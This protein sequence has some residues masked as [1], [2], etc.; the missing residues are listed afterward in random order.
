MPSFTFHRPSSREK[1]LLNHNLVIT[2]PDEPLFQWSKKSTTSPRDYLPRYERPYGRA[3][4][5]W[6][7]KYFGMNI[8]QFQTE[9]SMQPIR[10]DA[11]TLVT[12]F[13][14]DQDK[15]QR[16]SDTV[17]LERIERLAKMNEQIIIYVP[18]S[19]SQRIRDMRHDKHWHVIDI[20][21]TIW[22]I[23]NNRYQRDNFENVQTKLFDAFEGY[24]KHTSW[25][26]ERQYDHPHRS[27]TYNAKA[28]IMYDAIMRNPF[29]SDT[30]M[31]I[32]AGIFDEGGP[33]DENGIA[34]GDIIA[35]GV[36]NDKIRRAITVSGDSGVVMGEYMH[37]LA[38]GPRL[39]G[40]DCWEDP[41][42]SWMC[43]LFI[44]NVYVGST[45]GML[46]Y[47]IRYM[48]TVDDM[49]ANGIYSAREEF[50]MPWVALRYP[51]SIFS[52]PWIPTAGLSWRQWQC[53]AK[54]CFTAYG[55]SESVP[56]IVDPIQTLLCP[57][58]RPR[59]GPLQGG[60]LYEMTIKRELFVFMR[61]H[62]HS[63]GVRWLQKGVEKK[64]NE[65]K[66]KLLSRWK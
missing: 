47:S 23:P 17:Y 25:I 61:Q 28:F 2:L 43:R 49:D 45:I 55:G 8:P 51:N 13:Y 40:H 66:E 57:G 59:A 34:W 52:I 7:Q 62:Y 32:D 29:G 39:V 14:P 60:G 10:P 19:L 30:W 38:Y 26:P 11:S 24:K 21:E 20:Y 27:A 16:R 41:K 5:E 50:V 15:V 9:P 3:A 36:D 12:I 56:T 22:D 44:A 58:Y 1:I 63:I 64:L 42:K 4:A 31:Y 37:S 6:Q 18:P 33:S 65:V 35:S 46:N 53:P 48:H 54:T